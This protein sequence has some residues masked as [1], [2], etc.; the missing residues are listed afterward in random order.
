MRSVGITLM[1]I[2]DKDITRKEDFR[3][4][5]LVTVDAKI[6]NKIVSMQ[7]ELITHGVPG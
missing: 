1:L 5:F 4:I 2:R 3:A 7:K 6:L